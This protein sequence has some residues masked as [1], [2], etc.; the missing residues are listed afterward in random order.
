MNVRI[1]AS[2]ETILVMATDGTLAADRR[3]LVRLDV[4]VI[5]DSNGRRERGSSGGGGR[6]DL[7]KTGSPGGTAACD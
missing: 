4:S 5:V 7:R 2:H 1:A 3:P 6:F